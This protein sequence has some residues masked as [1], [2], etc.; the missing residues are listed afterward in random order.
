ML[1]SLKKLYKPG[2]FKEELDKQVKDARFLD[3]LF[4]D[5]ISQDSEKAEE[6]RINQYNTIKNRIDR[7][8]TAERNFYDNL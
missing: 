2:D 4:N 8:A 1:A 5:N 7:D 6:A 3:E